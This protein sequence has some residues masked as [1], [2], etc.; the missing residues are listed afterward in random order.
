MV[1]ESYLPDRISGAGTSSPQELAETRASTLELDIDSSPLLPL[2]MFSPG[3]TSSPEPG[4]NLRGGQGEI[5]ILQQIGSSRPV[6]SAS[7]GHAIIG[8]LPSSPVLTTPSRIIPSEHSS[9][10]AQGA[11]RP[12]DTQHGPNAVDGSCND[13]GRAEMVCE[14]SAETPPGL[15]GSARPFSRRP[16]N[17]SQET[18][19]R[20]RTINRRAMCIDGAIFNPRS[21]KRLS[22]NGFPVDNNGNIDEGRIASGRRSWTPPWQRSPSLNNWVQNMRQSMR[23]K[24]RID[25][26]NSQDLQFGRS[27]SH[28]SQNAA[29]ELPASETHPTLKS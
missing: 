2:E 24:F 4:P 3:W 26:N 18:S 16:A 12:L 27:V 1:R 11:R 25:S 14:Q 29:L 28:Q 7:Q 22:Q 23:E 21:R 9:F 5:S 20:R 19:W 13:G 17:E 6:P 15:S 8:G 10:S